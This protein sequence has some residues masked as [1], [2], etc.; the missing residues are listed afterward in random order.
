M[1]TVDF[2][3]LE[4]KPGFRILDIGCGAGRHTGAAYRQK[5]VSV[6]GGDLCF[7]DLL[8]AKE[9]LN[10]H[11]ELGDTGGGVWSLSVTDITNLPFR[12]D[13]FDLVIC[14]EVMEHIPA[15]KEAVD[16][17]L[18]VVKPGHDLVVSVPRYFPEKIC[19]ALS[20]EYHNN[21]GG[22]IRIYRKKRFISLFEKKGAAKWASHYAHSIHAPYWWLKCFV[23]PEREDSK[24]VN[25]YNRLLTWDI[26]KGPW[27][28]KFIDRLLNPVI[29]KSLVVYFRKTEA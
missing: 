15:E 8:Q 10:Y 9:R 6:I 11:D 14:S 1:I 18:R 29:G 16:E 3:K 4:I 2:D 21:E 26:M 25:L 27:I 24:A 7:S 20:D 13:F 19:W 28:T 5:G 17:L 22:H 23:G 12:D